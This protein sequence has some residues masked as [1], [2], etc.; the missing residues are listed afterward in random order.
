MPEPD[1]YARWSL[2]DRL[3]LL[4]FEAELAHLPPALIATIREAIDQEANLYPSRLGSRS[5]PGSCAPAPF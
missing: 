2:S 5:G 1:P 4:A 3:E